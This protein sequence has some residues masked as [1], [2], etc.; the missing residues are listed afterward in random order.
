MTTSSSPR[1][2]VERL[3]QAV[4]S[5]HPEDMADCYAAEVV[6]EMPFAVTALY[7]ARLETTRDE[8]RRRFKA[9]TAIRT[10]QRLD[11]VVVHE[12]ADPEV[13]IVEYDLHGELVRS[14]EAF[15]QKYLMVIT[16][17]DGEIVH[18]RDYTDP[19]AGA[20]ILGRLPELLTALG[21][22]QET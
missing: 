14:G 1:A 18:S 13:L 21:A 2:T 4:T 9:G 12:T 22:R 3:L 6:I 5:A 19:V 20:R 10:Y 8:L 11:N 16:V 17:R 15:V 7:P